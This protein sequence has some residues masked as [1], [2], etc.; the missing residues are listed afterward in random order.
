MARCP[1]DLIHGTLDVL[2]LKT[3]SW[4]PAHGYAISRAIEERTKGVFDLED[5]ALY[6][7]LHRLEASGAL[8]AEWGASENNRRAK[9]Y[10]LTAF[11]RKAL[12]AETTTWHKYAT[13]VTSVLGAA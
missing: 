3:L 10:T 6:K 4:Q 1:I 5:A 11:G 8:A 12:R 9:Y 13:A 2:V 7:A